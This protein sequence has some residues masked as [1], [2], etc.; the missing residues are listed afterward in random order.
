VILL[1]CSEFYCNPCQQESLILQGLANTYGPK[2]VVIL[3]NLSN[4]GT[5][6]VTAAELTEWATNAGIT[7]VPVLHDSNDVP[8][9]YALTAFPTNILIGKD[10]TI[11]AIQSGYNQTEV[12]AMITQGLQ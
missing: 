3:E 1:V 4:V 2:G 9:L 5:N 6:V 7:T 10:Y 8:T 12:T 11:L